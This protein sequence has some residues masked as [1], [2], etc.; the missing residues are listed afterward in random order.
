M[1]FMLRAIQLK[2][3]GLTNAGVARYLNRHYPSLEEAADLI[4]KEDEELTSIQQLQK[5]RSAKQLSSIYRS[6]K[7]PVH[8]GRPL[9]FFIMSIIGY[10]LISNF[11]TTPTHNEID[12]KSEEP[13]IIVDRPAAIGKI[14]V[15]I[16]PP[17]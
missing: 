3:F 17:S 8:I 6:I 1:F 7:V 4:L 11:A 16:T 2:V 10:L 14:D 9:L 13:S 5:D 12:Q 15:Q